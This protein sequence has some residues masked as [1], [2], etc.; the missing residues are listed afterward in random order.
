M[1]KPSKM[2]WDQTEKT[3]QIAKEHARGPEFFRPYWET[4]KGHW[5]L[6]YP[7]FDD[8]KGWKCYLTVKCPICLGKSFPPDVMKIR[9]IHNKFGITYKELSD[10]AHYAYGFVMDV[11]RGVKGADET[12]KLLADVAEEMAKEKSKDDDLD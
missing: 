7:D 4:K 3:R 6:I 12:V 5:E 9:K 10:R 8:I 2:F 11:A 1:K